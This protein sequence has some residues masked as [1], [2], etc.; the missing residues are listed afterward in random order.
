MIHVDISVFGLFGD[1]VISG[2]CANELTRVF[3]GKSRFRT[4]IIYHA[5]SRFVFDNWDYLI[6]FNVSNCTIKSDDD[7]NLCLLIPHDSIAIC[8][9]YARN[10]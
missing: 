5:V 6:A 7:I 8:K 10:Q 1:V 9:K 3:C 4:T 2:Y